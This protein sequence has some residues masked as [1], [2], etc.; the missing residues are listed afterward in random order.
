MTPNEIKAVGVEMIWDLM[1]H[2]EGKHITAGRPN[3]YKP[4]YRAMALLVAPGKWN[5]C[6]QCLG[7]GPDQVITKEDA[8][9]VLCEAHPYFA[10]RFEEHRDVYESNYDFMIEAWHHAR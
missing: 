2:S 5:S 10:E 8:I 3:P 9:A 1:K 7:W 4:S 6:T